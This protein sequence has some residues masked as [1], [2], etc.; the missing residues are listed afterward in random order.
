MPLRVR[1]LGTDDRLVPHDIQNV[2]EPVSVEV[3]AGWTRGNRSQDDGPVQ[4]HVQA[5]ARGSVGGE[6]ALEPVVE[7]V[8]VGDSLG[9]AGGRL[10]QRARAEGVGSG[11]LGGVAPGSLAV[12]DSGSLSLARVYGVASWETVIESLD[13]FSSLGAATLPVIV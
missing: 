2:D 5:S 13:G 12:A 4:H 1:A 6:V 3:E 9:Q 8:G 7:T 10:L 11:E